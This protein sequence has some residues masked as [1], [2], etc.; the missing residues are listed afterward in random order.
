MHK[1]APSATHRLFHQCILS[2]SSRARVQGRWWGLAILLHVLV[3][4][5]AGFL[6]GTMSVVTNPG[7]E[8]QRNAVVET[9]M[10]DIGGDLVSV[11][12]GRLTD[13]RVGRGITR[14][15]APNQVG[16]GPSAE[17]GTNP[18]PD[19]ETDGEYT[20][21][22]PDPSKNRSGGTKA[23]ERAVSGGLNWLSRHQ[24]ADGSWS[25]D[26]HS[27][28]C[29]DTSCTG[30]GVN[31]STAAATAFALLP[32][33]AAGQTHQSK[34]PYQAIIIKGLDSLKQSALPDGN[35]QRSVRSNYAQGIATI[36]LC[37]AYG[38]TKDENLKDPA[39]QAIHYIISAQHPELGGWHYYPP[40]VTPTAGDLSV[41]GWQLQALKSAELAGLDV[42]PEVWDKA[43]KFLASVSKGKSGGLCSYMVESGPTPAMTAVGMLSKQFLGTKR[44]DPAL[45][46]GAE[47]LLQNKPGESARNTYYFYYATQAM[48][49]QSGSAWDEWNRA[50]RKYLIETQEK[51]GCASGSWNPELPRKVVFADE[52]GRLL[53]TSMNTLNLEVYYRFLPLYKLD[54]P[55]KP[56][57]APPEP[58]PPTP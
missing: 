24:N 25:F 53:L 1:P 52:G 35:L 58:K 27:K 8:P 16:D 2:T 57:V 19:H 44:D 4:G 5:L 49:N 51:K 40:G 11:R 7:D 15:G 48:H 47:Y 42:P 56:D 26:G 55:D 33:L 29:K 31:Q 50:T 21:P 10:W 12:D 43:R 28:H 14:P 22:K 36:A 23:T 20:L 41:T 13:L 37:E 46:E 32:F 17:G 18:S 54:K 45:I 3:L 9:A 34:G 30:D 6:A 38:M 39:Q